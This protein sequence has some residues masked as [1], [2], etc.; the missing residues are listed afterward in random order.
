MSEEIK[1]EN[2]PKMLHYPHIASCNKTLSEVVEKIISDGRT[3]LTIGGDHS[4]GKYFD[5]YCK[6]SSN[7]TILNIINFNTITQLSVDLE[8]SL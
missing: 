3:C 1:N 7:I 8:L 5:N 6:I 4:I 2:I